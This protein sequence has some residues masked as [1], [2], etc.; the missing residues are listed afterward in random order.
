MAALALSGVFEFEYSGFIFYGAL[1]SVLHDYRI[2]YVRS[3]YSVAA[4]FLIQGGYLP[5][6]WCSDRRYNEEPL[7]NQHRSR[8]GPIVSRAKHWGRIGP[9]NLLIRFGLFGAVAANIPLKPAHRI[10]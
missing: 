6:G 8:S 1:H 2:A 7:L 4:I 9:I 5:D 10:F 3:A